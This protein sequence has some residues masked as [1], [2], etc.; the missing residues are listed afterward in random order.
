KSLLVQA[1]RL[2][3]DYTN[4]WPVSSHRF[5][6]VSRR[7]SLLWYLIAGDSNHNLKWL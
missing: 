2:F 5:G 1:N 6:I 4:C 7:N 3:C